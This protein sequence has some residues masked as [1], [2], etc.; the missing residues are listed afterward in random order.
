[1][2]RLSIQLAL[3][4]A[5]VLGLAATVSLRAAETLPDIDVII[6][7][8]PG[9]VMAIEVRPPEGYDG[10][11]VSDVDVIL[12]KVPG[13]QAFDGVRLSGDR[14]LRDLTISELPTGWGLQRKGRRLEL[15]GPAVLPPVRFRLDASSKRPTKLD[16]ELLADGEVGVA[17]RGIVPREVPVRSVAGTLS[18]TVQLPPRVSPGETIALRALPD[19][20]LPPNGAWVISGTVSEPFDDEELRTARRTVLNP[21]RS[22]ILLEAADTSLA[23]IG[24]GGCHELAPTAAAMLARDNFNT[25]KSNTIELAIKEREETWT[26]A[27]RVSQLDTQPT[28]VAAP[29]PPT[30]TAYHLLSKGKIG[31]GL[32]SSYAFALASGDDPGLRTGFAINEESIPVE[33]GAATSINEEEVRRVAVRGPR[34]TGS[35][36]PEISIQTVHAQRL[37]EIEEVVIVVASL[38]AEPVAGGCRFQPREPT[39]T[40]LLRMAQ[41]PPRGK[42]TGKKFGSVAKGVAGATGIAHLL[43]LPKDLS[44]GEPLSIR[45]LDEWGD[46][47][48]EVAEVPDVEVVPAE[49]PPPRRIE[50][51]GRY[52]IAGRSVCVCGG[53]DA[54]DIA[55][56]FRLG[57]QVVQPTSVS[58]T[59]AW[60]SVPSD[61]LGPTLIQAD[62]FRGEAATDVIQIGAELDQEHLFSGQQTP[63]RLT[64][65]GTTQSVPIRLVNRTPQVITLEGGNEQS[66]E[67]PGG[68][69][70]VV[71]RQVSAQ[72]R[73]SFQLNWEMSPAPCP[74]T[75][76]LP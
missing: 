27:N 37:T 40:E 11:P 47:W 12:Q 35:A 65:H 72:Q 6:E 17:E 30:T 64:V 29:L 33:T 60:L 5:L 8:N 57:E 67:S 49:D 21:T 39:E 34:T 22:H 66:T 24:D 42:S 3:A 45:Y 18:G 70:N 1:M 15:S 23:L 76:E 50:S 43:T 36:D 41:R 31:A 54:L 52:V 46:P 73:G 7:Q 32:R 19:A 14:A 68:T 20:N 4:A 71:T 13:G 59:T 61:A 44:P 10:V 51:A 56:P 74:C 53:F 63:L 58:R 69:E 62:G 26:V 48:V 55:T 2:H 28:F 16:V 25:S 75:E 38:A 9:G